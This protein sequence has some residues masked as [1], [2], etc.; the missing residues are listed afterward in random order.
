MCGIGG[1]DWTL[2]RKRLPHIYVRDCGDF[3]LRRADRPVDRALLTRMTRT[4][5]HRGPD[6]EGFYVN[7][8]VGLGHRRL[9]IVD[10]TPTGAQPMATDDGSCWISYNGEFYNHLEFRPRLAARGGHF[11]GERRIPRRCCG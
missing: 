10:L 7:G 5:A 9:S 2:V 11:P 8:N 4:L 1:R 6:A 3:L